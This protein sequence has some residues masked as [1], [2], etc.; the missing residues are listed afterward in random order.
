MS[1][2]KKA[3]E[4]KNLGQEAYKRKEYDVAISHYSNATRLNPK[5][6]TFIYHIAK[7]HLEQKNYAESIRFSTKAIKV[8]KEEKANVKMVAKAMAMRGRAHKECGETTKYEED[9]DKAVK[10]LTMIAYVKFDK[11]RW[12]EC[13]DFCQR[14]YEMGEENDFVDAEVLVLQSK[15]TTRLN[16][17]TRAEDLKKLGNE[18]YNKR[19]FDTALK[20]YNDASKLNPKEITFLNNIAAVKL[21]Q[22][23]LTECILFCTKAMNMGKENGA[24]P[25]KI[26]KALNRRDKAVKLLNNASEVNKQL[27]IGLN[28]SD[29]SETIANKLKR[30]FIAEHPDVDPQDVTVEIISDK[31]QFIIHAKGSLSLSYEFTSC[32]SAALPEVYEKGL[33]EAEIKRHFIANHLDLLNMTDVY[34]VSLQLYEM[35]NFMGCIVLCRSA[36][37]CGKDGSGSLAKVR[38]LRGKAHRR[39]FGWAESYDAKLAEGMQ[40][41]CEGGRQDYVTV[42]WVQEIESSGNM[43][44][45]SLF[46][47]AKEP[48]R[49]E[50]AE[51]IFSMADLNGDRK[52]RRDQILLV[53][54]VMSYTNKE[55]GRYGFKFL[56][57][58]SKDGWI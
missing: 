54:S 16:Q 10:F 48:C 36:E 6:M 1:E 49:P 24:D 43:C 21:E 4:E 22:G 44:S 11:E 2:E 23:S 25:K 17:V 34:N 53:S 12:A 3:L 56:E 19:D 55:L 30:R 5:E 51:Q 28:Y 8:G 37:I 15:A 41:H 40:D 13:I 29:D 45:G 9:I 52:V 58:E 7:I 18:A 57:P 47:G 42:E 38:A 27:Q 35:R 14:A 26:E 39:D 20:Y 50:E 33:F 31:K 32:Q 46:T